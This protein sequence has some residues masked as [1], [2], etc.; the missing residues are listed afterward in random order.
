MRFWK[1][2]YL[3]FRDFMRKVRDENISSFAAS[4]AFFL[5]VSLI[6]LVAVL[7]ALLPY[8]P[9][10]EEVILE[11]MRQLAP[12]M[13]D[14]LFAQIVTDIYSASSGVLTISVIVAVWS[15]G[16]GMLALIRGLNSINDITEKRNYVVLRLAASFYTIIMLVAVIL[17]LIILMFGTSL[18]TLVRDKFPDTIRHISGLVSFRFVITLVVF[19]LVLTIIYT[20]VPS[21]KMVLKKQIPGAFFS[22]LIWSVTSWGFSVYIDVFHGFSTYGSLTTVIAVLIYMYAML[23]I[24][25]IGA[26][27]NRYFGPIYRLL[28]G[29]LFRR[30]KRM[31]KDNVQSKC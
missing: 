11:V 12:E 2:V 28:F 26:Y 3:I 19:T 15:A 14:E 7:C 10:T 21:A 23:Y 30:P 27:I 1:K 29:R 17:M 9:V 16:K 8:T 25:L 18:L 22:A 13:V 24:A 6:P 4:A 5:F 20:Y 31:P